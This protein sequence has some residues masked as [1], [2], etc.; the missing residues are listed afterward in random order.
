MRNNGRQPLNAVKSLGD[1]ADLAARGIHVITSGLLSRDV[2][3]QVSP[4]D[5]SLHPPPIFRSRARFL[6][7]LF[8]LFLVLLFLLRHLLPLRDAVKLRLR[9]ERVALPLIRI[10]TR[11]FSANLGT[12]WLIVI[13]KFA[14]WFARILIRR[15]VSFLRINKKYYLCFNV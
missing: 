11:L 12:P 8:L 4:R 15:K 14:Y 10:S 1:N 9:A 5:F 13:R 2:L 3:L 7:L 6:L